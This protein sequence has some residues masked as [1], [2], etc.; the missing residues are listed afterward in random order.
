MKMKLNQVA[1]AVVLAFPMLASAQS[2]AELQSQIQELKAQINQ[3]RAMIAPNAS[4]PVASADSSQVQAVDPEEFNQVKVKVD[5]IIDQQIT[6]GIKGLRISGGFDPVY[7]VNKAK[8]TSSFAFLN[9]FSGINGSSEVYSYDNSYF[10]MAYLDVQKEM[11]DGGTKFRLTLAPSKSAGAQYNFGNIVHEASASI[12][13]TDPQTRLVVGQMPDVSGYQPYVNTFAGA[14][15]VTS[16]MLYPG[17]AEYFITKNMLFDFT[18]MTTYTGAGLD[19]TRGPWET[20]LFLANANSARNDNFCAQDGTCT[21]KPNKQPLFVYNATYAQS[22]FWGVEFTGYEGQVANLAK[23]DGST[24]RLDQFE[25][26][27][28]YTRGD[29]SGNL[30]AT[31]GR[32]A[33]AAING[34]DAQWWGLSAMASQRVTPKLTLAARADYIQNDKNGGGT[35]NVVSDGLNGFGPDPVCDPTAGECKGANRYSLSFAATYR[36]TT[37]VALRAEYRRDHSTLPT[38]YNYG[39]GTYSNTND[40]FGLQAIVNF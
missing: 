38:F 29:F 39:D 25:I 35:F 12:P 30:Q 2:N 17:F 18:G 16:N 26:D 23:Y 7:M 5:A 22:E 36:L 27:G 14:N 6:A 37:N 13:L 40:V 19:I 11:D 10:G 1:F 33:D 9:N 20:K 21:L 4:A 8:G 32:Q 3:L 34:G 31:I 24:N 28:W 15:N